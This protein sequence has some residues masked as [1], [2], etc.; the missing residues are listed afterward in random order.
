[1]Y[2]FALWSGKFLIAMLRLFGKGG[3]A[4]PGLVALA[5]DKNFLHKAATKV[6][7]SIIITGTNGKT[8][9]AKMTE[10]ILRDC[11]YKVFRNSAG[12]NMSR[13]VASS[14]IEHSG[15]NG[16]IHAEWAVLEVDEAFSPIIASIFKPQVIVALNLLRDQLDRYGELDTTA[17]HIGKA[18]SYSKTTILNLDDPLVAELSEHA[19]GKVLYFGGTPELASQLPHDAVLHT[20]ASNK[21]NKTKR[22]PDILL[23]KATTKGV[24]QTIEFEY[25]NQ[26]LKTKLQLPGVYNAYNAMAAFMVGVTTGVDP[27]EVTISLSKAK[28]AFGRAENVEIDGKTLQILL[29]KN[30]AGYNQII[31]TFLSSEKKQNLLLAVNDKIADGRDVSWL[32]DVDFEKLSKQSHNIICSGIRGY[33]LAVRLKY[34]D[35]ASVTTTNLNDALKEHVKSLPA[36]GLGYVVPTYTAML[37]VRK[38]LNKRAAMGEL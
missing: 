30:P 31:N 38:I 33:D 11:G 17:G 2:L 27:K 14:F 8:T 34:A 37:E 23:S 5:V 18:I 28:P 36:G 16:R 6:K 3:S 1:M 26:S 35:I 12:S 25:N 13:G 4:L 20:H 21:S 24:G 9:T 32:W 7:G 15:I 19:K 10:Q 29:V 22:N